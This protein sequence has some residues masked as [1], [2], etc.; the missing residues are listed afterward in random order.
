MKKNARVPRCTLLNGSAWSA[1]NKF[2]NRYKG[3][4]DMFS[5]GIEHRM[6]K[7]EIEE[8]FNRDTKE[9]CRFAADA[10]RTTDE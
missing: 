9:G 3:T 10:G 6:R 4:F 1:E 2:M 7:E 5:F 8:Q